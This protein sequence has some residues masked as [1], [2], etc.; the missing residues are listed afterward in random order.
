M[1]RQVKC[2][3]LTECV[4]FGLS[5]VLWLFVLL[6]VYIYVYLKAQAE[7]Q[8][9]ETEISMF[10]FLQWTRISHKVSGIRNTNSLLPGCVFSVPA[11]K[12]KQ[13][14][15]YSLEKKQEQ[16]KNRNNFHSTYLRKLFFFFTLICFS[17]N[18]KCSKYFLHKLSLSSLLS[19]FFHLPRQ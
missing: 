14:K 2:I 4:Y 5:I 13:I 1:H 9:T 18:T 11:N 17:C 16:Q 12:L 8:K 6:I 19:P 10:Y 15:L 7:E 3:W